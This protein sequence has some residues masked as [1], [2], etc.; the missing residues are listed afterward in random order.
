[1]AL[2]GS[3]AGSE[4]NYMFYNGS[5]W[6]NEFVTS[7][8]GL[9]SGLYKAQCEVVVNGTMYMLYS[10]WDYITD[11]RLGV[12]NGSWHFS[13]FLPDDRYWGGDSSVAFDRTT[14]RTY[15]FYIDAET[16]QVL[17]AYTTDYV[18]WIKDLKVDATNSEYI[19]RTR[20]SKFCDVSP[21]VAWIM[22]SDAPFHIKF[23]L[24]PSEDNSTPPARAFG[25]V[26]PDRKVDLFD[27][28][29]AA[30]AFGCCPRDQK[31]NPAADQNQDNM[32]DIYDLIIIA[33][34]FGTEYV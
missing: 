19:R 24:L 7:G 27:A 1:M 33:K 13:D 28:V 30:S 21:A 4:F 8:S 29:T 18:S 16:N 2:Y 20:T 5:E 22:G 10:H 31:W 23:G 11:L 26:N 9:E 6:S 34:K 12:Y 15:F 32:V 3:W 25:D 14:N 17:A